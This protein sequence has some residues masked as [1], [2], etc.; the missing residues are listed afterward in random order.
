MSEPETIRPYLRSYLR[1]EAKGYPVPALST[2]SVA[3]VMHHG[4]LACAPDA[5]LSTV[6]R[7]M[8]S[9]GVHCVLVGGIAGSGDPKGGEHLVWRVLTDADLLA[10]VARDD[11]DGRAAD[12]GATEAPT[13][14]PSAPLADAV[15][16]MT[17]HRV[18]HLI[19]VDPESERPAGVVSAS[20]VVRSL[21]LGGP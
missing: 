7:A 17:E 3:D 5:S 19:V 1:P 15:Q 8:E 13:I 12:A 4:V 21:A 16:V 6:A 14:T 9:H 2:A 11:S 10:A 18:T 20:D